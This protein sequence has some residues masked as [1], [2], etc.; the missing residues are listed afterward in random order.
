MYKHISVFFLLSQVSFFLYRTR[1]YS[2]VHQPCYCFNIDKNL[3]DFGLQEEARITPTNE[4]SSAVA[5]SG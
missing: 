5:K 1:L 2:V 3:Q 4:L